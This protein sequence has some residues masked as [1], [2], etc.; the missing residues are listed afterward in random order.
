[1]VTYRAAKQLFK[2]IFAFVLIKGLIL[3]YDK[4]ISCWLSSG[5]CYR[6]HNVIEPE[7]EWERKF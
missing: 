1:M 3:I 6:Q 5:W 7:S 2:H 4:N